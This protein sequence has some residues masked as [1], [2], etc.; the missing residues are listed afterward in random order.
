MTENKQT[1]ERYM[2]GFRQGDHAGILACLTDDVVW[3]IPGL[4]RKVGKQE[5]D[6]EIENP[7]FQGRPEIA[8]A[9]LT[10]EDDVVIAE[11]T[12]RAQKQGGGWLTLAYCDVFEMRGGR[13]KRLVSYLM[14]VKEGAA[15]G[16]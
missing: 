2:Q 15:V 8:V 9:R 16:R 7:A 13:I 11:G 14:E 3:E 12:V 5:F 1:V 6:G 10:E 4:F